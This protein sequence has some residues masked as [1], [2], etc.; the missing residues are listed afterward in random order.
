MLTAPEIWGQSAPSGCYLRGFPPLEGWYLADR[1]KARL[2]RLAELG[3][4]RLD[5]DPGALLDLGFDLR[6]A[7]CAQPEDRDRDADSGEARGDQEGE[8]VAAAEGVGR[9]LAARDASELVRSVAIVPSAARPIAAESWI[10][11]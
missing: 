9:V 1:P 8:V 11:T 2:S 3:S 4:L 10:E 7:R 5:A 6:G